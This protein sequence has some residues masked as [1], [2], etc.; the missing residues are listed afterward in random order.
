MKFNGPPLIVPDPLQLEHAI[1]FKSPH[2]LH[3]PSELLIAKKTNTI[4]IMY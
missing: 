4:C 3:I 1:S 2:F